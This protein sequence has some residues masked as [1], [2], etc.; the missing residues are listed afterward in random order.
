[1][2]PATHTAASFPAASA[3]DV[4]LVRAYE[5]ASADSPL[6][7]AE[8]RAWA[9]RVAADACGADATPERFLAERARHALQRLQPR[10][11]QLERW[12]GRRTRGDGWMVLVT[13]GTLA[14]GALIDQIGASQHI[15]L[16][17]PWV[18]A[19]VAWNLLV[20]VLAV[21]QALRPVATPG[22]PRRAVQAL[23]SVRAPKSPAL[24]RYVHDWA[25]HAEPQHLARSVALLHLAAASLAAGLLAGMYLRGL[26]LDYRAGWQSTFLDAEAVHALL[27][28]LLAP[29]S[30]VTGLAV[31]DAATLAAM[32]VGPDAPPQA[33]AAAW[34]HL[35]AATLGMTVIV[36]RLLLAGA[37]AWRA[38]RLSLRWTLELGTPYF[39]QL[40]HRRRRGASGVLVVPHAAPTTARAALAL[41]SLLGAAADDAP[42]L[43][44][45]EPVTYGEEEAAA[46]VATPAGTAL[47]L[48]CFDLGSGPEAEAQGRMIEAMSAAEPSLPLAV[49]VDESAFVRRFGQLPERL[50]ERRAAWQRFAQQR[51]VPL[52]C[53]NLEQP[54]PS[55]SAQLRRLLEA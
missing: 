47:R 6:W 14:A 41:K 24:R 7:T 36:P 35:F 43:T 17:A 30:A 50:T 33:P 16:L 9:T 8:D 10:D 12:R 40:L 18:W 26:V 48:A 23:W 37:A 1:M 34:L 53:I 2:N 25:E 11:P 13:A 32:R 19:L 45:A 46:H 22:W 21:W 5:T 15:N 27:R 55:A 29:A 49:L 31:P 3:R 39:Q 42:S 28:T 44:I 54:G 52:A 38:H 4:L 51:S 20:Y